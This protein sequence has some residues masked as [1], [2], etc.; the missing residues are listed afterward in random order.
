MTAHQVGDHEQRDRPLTG[1]HWASGYVG[2][3]AGLMLILLM[4]QTGG[5]GLHLVGRG[6]LGLVGIPVGTALLA[7]AVLRGGYR[8]AG[9]GLL[10]ATPASWVAYAAFFLPLWF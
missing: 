7:A 5:A 3:V 10:M 1:A 2:F 6:A 8:L 9:L 4:Y